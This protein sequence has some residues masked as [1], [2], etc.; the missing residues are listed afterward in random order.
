MQ[1]LPSSVASSLSD[2]SLLESAERWPMT[3]RE[4]QYLYIQR[5]FEMCEGNKKRAAK[6]LGIGR[7]SLYRYLTRKGIHR[8]KYEHAYKNRARCSF[9]SSSLEKALLMSF[10]SGTSFAVA[11]PLMVMVLSQILKPNF[12]STRKA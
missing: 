7:I 1:P 2:D 5:V 6:I 12:G 10:E 11:P 9:L 4:F 8:P 3:L